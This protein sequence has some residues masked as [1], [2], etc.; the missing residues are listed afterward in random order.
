MGPFAGRGGIPGGNTDRNKVKD[1]NLGRA[2]V[3]VFCSGAPSG[4]RFL[5]VR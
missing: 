5:R 3:Q 1:K 2:S 4:A